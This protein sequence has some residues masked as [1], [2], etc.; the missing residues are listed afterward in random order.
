[1]FPAKNRIYGFGRNQPT[2]SVICANVSS[3]QPFSNYETNKFSDKTSNV[4]STSV[5]SC[6]VDEFSVVEK[7]D[8]NRQS[9]STP[10]CCYISAN[11]IDNS[12][13]SITSTEQKLPAHYLDVVGKNKRRNRRQSPTHHHPQQQQQH[14]NECEC[15]LQARKS[16]ENATIKSCHTLE[17]RKIINVGHKFN[18]NGINSIADQSQ[19]DAN[20]VNPNEFQVNKQKF[21]CLDYDHSDQCCFCC[22]SD[23]KKGPRFKANYKCDDQSV[24]CAQLQTNP[25]NF[26]CIGS[27]D[28]NVNISHLNNNCKLYKNQNNEQNSFCNS[29]RTTKTDILEPKQC[30]THEN[31]FDNSIP[32][33]WKNQS[34]KCAKLQKRKT[35]PIST[36]KQSHLNYLRRVQSINENC[37]DC[38]GQLDKRF[39]KQIK[40]LQSTE[41]CPKSW[42]YFSENFPCAQEEQQKLVCCSR[43]TAA[44]RKTATIFMIGNDSTALVGNI[45][46]LK[47][48]SEL[49]RDDDLVDT[50]QNSVNYKNND[51]KTQYNRTFNRCSHK[52][53]DSKNRLTSAKESHSKNTNC[54]QNINYKIRA[55]RTHKHLKSD[56][57]ENEHLNSV[58]KQGK[59][60]NDSVDDDGDGGDNNNNND[61]DNDN[62]YLC[63][64]EK[65]NLDTVEQKITHISSTYPDDNGATTTHTTAAPSLTT[66]ASESVKPKQNSEYTVIAC[67]DQSAISPS[68]QCKIVESHQ[69]NVESGNAHEFQCELNISDC[70][71][72]N[73]SGNLLVDENLVLNTK[74]DN[75]SNEECTLFEHKPIR[76]LLTERSQ[77]FNRRASFDNSIEKDLAI[78]VNH[79]RT[80][81]SGGE[82]YSFDRQSK[83]NRSYIDS[84][85]DRFR[86]IQ[87]TDHRY[88][89]Y[90]TPN[91]VSY[92]TNTII[93]YIFHFYHNI[94]SKSN[95]FR[96]FLRFSSCI[97][98]IL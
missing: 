20:R 83:L 15:S 42:P 95:V 79:R 63:H 29:D 80:A 86:Y 73:S 49:V 31:S 17:N 19:I 3:Q 85:S 93:I 52:S 7:D 10:I 6:V 72:I 88:A 56:C 46:K 4:N 9:F 74:I 37:S 92:I 45:P 33:N 36:S 26:R 69:I 65:L 96:P 38:I 87:N 58:K 1:M 60:H 30:H 27:G 53:I 67:T 81:S 34:D 47:D 59:Q 54:N 78:F 51:L 18:S 68:D 5:N 14:Q 57:D 71:N 22:Y 55:D 16:N 35:D 32:S 84:I 23:C 50:C 64:L 28:A 41:Y 76:T 98:S 82:G 44:V 91:T 89:H 25:S 94:S 97:Y 90:L 2:E 13:K 66:V 48:K 8:E 24:E 11:Q 75:I 62:D 61:Q 77:Q 12:H 40:R 21:H 43:S 39:I 70:E